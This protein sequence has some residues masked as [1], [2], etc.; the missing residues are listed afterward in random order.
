MSKNKELAKL[1][2][3]TKN[4]VTEKYLIHVYNVRPK[5]RIQ[6][7]HGQNY[8]IFMSFLYVYTYIYV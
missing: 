8:P 2:Y 4:D 1:S 3:C 6:K 7:P 5:S